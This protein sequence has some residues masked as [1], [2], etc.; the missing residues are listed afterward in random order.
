MVAQRAIR[1]YVAARGGPANSQF[2]YVLE[3]MNGDG[4]NDALALFTLPYHH[5][6]GMAG[7]TM[8]VFEGRGGGFSPVTEI[9]NVYGPVILTEEI[10]AGWR[11]IAVRASGTTRRD[12]DVAL[13]FDGAQ[14]P[15]NPLGQPAL[16]QSLYNTPGRRIFP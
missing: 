4:R 14:Y 8:M 9:T 15:P 3:D 7:C 5:W 11:D 1:Q 10:S 2:R 6:C 13:R 12:R 16:G